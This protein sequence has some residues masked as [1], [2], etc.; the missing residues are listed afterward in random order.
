[1]EKCFTIWTERKTKSEIYRTL[2]D[3]R[4]YRTSSLQI[5]VDVFLILMLRKYIPDPSHVLES[6]PVQLKENFSYEEEPVWIFD[7]KE[8][9]LS[10]KTILL[11]NVLWRSHEIEEAT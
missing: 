8:R 6:Q 10:S 2:R 1:M 9:V 7:K 4:A 3:L 11:V 5:R